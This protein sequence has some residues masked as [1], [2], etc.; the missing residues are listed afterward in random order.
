MSSDKIVS[1]TLPM[2]KGIAE[3]ERCF[4]A[5]NKELYNSE[6]P[7][8]VITI[9]AA[10][11]KNALGWFCGNAWNVKENQIP[12]INLSAEHL[13]RSVNEILQTLIHE[14]VHLDN[15]VNGISDCSASQY[16]NRKFK[17][18]AEK[19]GLE[20]EKSKHGWAHTS[21]TPGLEFMI[22]KVRP[23]AEALSTFRGSEGEGKKGKKGSKL[24]KW[25]CGCTNVRVA[26]EDFDATCNSCGEAFKEME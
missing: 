11:K 12:E 9:Q 16:H 1:N 17:V 3:L 5:F 25:S 14:M 21:L 18:A 24:K 6:L 15:Y 26:V 22:R 7:T 10:G 23:D 20:V 2:S 13:N 19:I 8:P 4:D